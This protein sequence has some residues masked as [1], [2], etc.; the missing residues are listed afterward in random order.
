MKR[1]AILLSVLI[2]V[3]PCL[4]QSQ[5]TS[6][7]GQNEN[8][9][10]AGLPGTAQTTPA[11]NQSARASVKIAEGERIILRNRFGPIVVTGGKGDT[12]EATATLTQHGT[13]AYK[14][15]VVT[16]R[17]AKDKIMITTDV[18]TASQ[19][20]AE[21]KEKG[22]LPGQS[23]G[24][25]G[26]SPQPPPKPQPAQ[27]PSTLPQP[28]PGAGGGSNTTRVSRAARP[29]RTPPLESLRGVGE[30]KLEVK[31]PHDARIELVD[32][33]RYAIVTSGTPSYL[34]NTRNNVTVT[35]IDTPVSIVSSGE[36]Q[37]TKV[38]A[39]EVKTRAGNIQVRD[40]AGLV[41]VSTVMGAIQV[42]G[43]DGDVRA[44]SVSGPISI[45]CARGRIEASTT[46]GTITLSGIGGD[47]DASTTGGG[48]TFTGAIRDDGRYRLR[49]MSGQVRMLIQREPP[50]FL[51][52]LSSYKGQMVVGFQLKTEL[53]ASTATSDL[54]ATQ[55]QPV[56]RLMGRFNDGGARITLDSFSATVEL[57][58][59]S[60]EAW[61]KCK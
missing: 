5:T 51:A 40:V 58:R 52:S 28:R 22:M 45:E 16:S 30:I 50:G 54:P 25:G 37:V 20:K 9:K 46:N 24:T 1:V 31:L 35:N 43:T 11:N 39:V 60:S 10:R 14:F 56:R 38:G 6:S 2:A 3:A 27:S 44:V 13:G 19:A 53:S 41:T 21:Q 23:S 48:I 18:T 8:K 15:Q 34:T 47:V 36:V 29:D 17:P 12:V 33:R 59:A 7:S 49:S 61:K 26:P 57:G 55:G 4:A 32:S 42:Q